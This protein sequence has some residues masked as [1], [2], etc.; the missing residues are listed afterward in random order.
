QDTVTVAYQPNGNDYQSGTATITAAISLAN[1]A[2]SLTKSLDP[3][4]YG[5]A[6]TLSGA[7][8]DSTPGSSKTPTGSVK[9]LFSVPNAQAASYICSDGS[10]SS[11]VCAVNL[12]NGAY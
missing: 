9:L 1:T 5:Q 11:T 6:V 7:V 12:D 4:T 10:I 8:T 3:T 2:V